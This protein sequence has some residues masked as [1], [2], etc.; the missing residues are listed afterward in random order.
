MRDERDLMLP[1]T[2]EGGIYRCGTGGASVTFD[3]I[4]VDGDINLS[5]IGNIP[6]NR[7]AVTHTAGS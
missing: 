1:D 5:S 3:L 7:G 6:V 2:L 4:T